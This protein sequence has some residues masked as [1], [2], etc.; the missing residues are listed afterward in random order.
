MAVRLIHA[1]FVSGRGEYSD[2]NHPP[3]LRL[4]HPIS[5]K[6][7]T[8]QKSL[9][10]WLFPLIVLVALLELGLNSVL[11]DV[12]LKIFPFFAEPEGYSFASLFTPET[13]TQFAGNWGLLGL[14]VAL[15]IFNTFLGEEFLFRGVLLPKTPIEK[16]KVDK[17]LFSFQNEVNWTEVEYISKNFEVGAWFPIM[18][19][20]DFL[21]LDDSIGWQ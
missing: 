5:P 12:W 14:F 9:W 17:T 21:L 15:A 10:W 2:R 6:T 8:V 20:R 7:G 19:N 3:P 13:R 16:I 1:H 11:T 4:N 18:V